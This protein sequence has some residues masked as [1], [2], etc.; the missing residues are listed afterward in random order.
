MPSASE[1][2]VGNCK[3]N[4]EVIMRT[5]SYINKISWRR[6]YSH[7]PVSNPLITVHNT[8]KA[9][10]QT[11]CA[12][13][14]FWLQLPLKNPVWINNNSLRWYTTVER[15]LPWSWKRPPPVM[16]TFW[17]F[18]G[19]CLQDLWLQIMEM[20]FIWLIKLKGY[21]KYYVRNILL[22]FYKL[23]KTKMNQTHWKTTNKELISV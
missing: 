4:K 23:Q 12:N 20:L 17:N 14:Q 3:Q 5:A 19:G 1:F 15:V 6:T 22:K 21:Y 16:T 13:K 10:F 8:D 11:A 7:A 18:W 2:W 9:L